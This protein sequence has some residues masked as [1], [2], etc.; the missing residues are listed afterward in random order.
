MEEPGNDTST[1]RHVGVA[2]GCNNDNV[3]I[4]TSSEVYVSIIDQDQLFATDD[5]NDDEPS[6]DAPAFLGMVL[7]ANDDNDE[8][9][10]EHEDM[11]D[12]EPEQLPV[13]SS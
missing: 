10:S 9:E 2:Y 8:S 7:T 1:V 4:P 12:N 11:V 5:D 3:Y 6:D 13:H